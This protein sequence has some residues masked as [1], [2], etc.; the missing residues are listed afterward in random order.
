MNDDTG[1]DR[2]KW[3][4]TMVVRVI[5]CEGQTNVAPFNVETVNTVSWSSDVCSRPSG[6]NQCMM[7]KILCV[8]AARF[9]ETKLIMGLFDF[10]LN[11]F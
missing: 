11:N 10:P 8:W 2:L 7:H 6:M 4:T 5:S 9:L 1:N 3:K